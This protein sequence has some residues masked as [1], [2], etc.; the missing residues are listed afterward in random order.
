MTRGLPRKGD[1]LFTTAAP[2]G[3]VA[4]VLDDEPFALGERL[5]LPPTCRRSFR[6][7]KTFIR[8]PFALWLSGRHEHDCSAPGAFARDFGHAATALR[9]KR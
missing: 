3:S 5:H 7:P 6:C 1:V 9:A 2:M 4:V 8:C